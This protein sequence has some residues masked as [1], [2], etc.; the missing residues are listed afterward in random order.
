MRKLDLY[1]AFNIVKLYYQLFINMNTDFIPFILG[2]IKTEKSENF[3]NE[4]TKH[5]NSQNSITLLM[6][7]IV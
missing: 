3:D 4:L 1:F 2:C 6:K 5:D 7:N